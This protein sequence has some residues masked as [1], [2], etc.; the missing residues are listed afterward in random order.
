MEA[1]ARVQRCDILDRA[2]Y[3]V[4]RHLIRPELMAQKQLRQVLVADTLNFMFECH[5]TVRYQ[6]QEILRVEGITDELRIGRELDTYNL[7]LGGPGELGCTLLVELGGAGCHRELDALSGLESCLYVRMPGGHAVHARATTERPSERP[8]L[9]QFLSFAVAGV[10]PA[11]VGC[12]H[13]RLCAEVELT[14]AQRRALQR[15][16]AVGLHAE[17][18]EDLVLPNPCSQ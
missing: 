5:A 14:L 3:E 17:V 2:A 16:L 10:A 8:S 13:P 1:R 15:D 12:S 6:I 11:A 9:V 4:L 7:L 18:P